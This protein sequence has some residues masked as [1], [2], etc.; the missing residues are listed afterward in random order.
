[1]KRFFCD[2]PLHECSVSHVQ[3]FAT[4]WIVAHQAPLSTEFS[5]KEYRRRLP[6]PSTG[7]LTHPGIKHTSLVSL[8]LAGRFFTTVPPGKAITHSVQFSRSVVSDP[9]RLHESQHAS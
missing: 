4:P 5:R 1:M 8:A 2:Y 3:L 9:L 6:F 7:D